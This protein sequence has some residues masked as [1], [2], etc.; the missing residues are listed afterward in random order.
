VRLNV[1]HWKRQAVHCAGGCVLGMEGHGTGY[2]ARSHGRIE[3][4]LLTYAG[5]WAAERC[6]CQNSA[7]R[8][9]YFVIMNFIWVLR[10]SRASDA[11]PLIIRECHGTKYS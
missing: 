5:W 9:E 1:L 8:A 10:V 4:A 11:H 2:A 7:T 3:D 6:C